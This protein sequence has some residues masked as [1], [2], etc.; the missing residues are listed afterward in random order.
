MRV[1]VARLRVAYASGMLRLP[2]WFVT[3]HVQLDGSD[4]TPCDVPE[5]AMAFT[6]VNGMLEFQLAHEG[7]EWK[8]SLA[9][10]RDGLIIVIADLHR[11]GTTT[12]V[13]DSETDGTGG[14]QV[15]LTDLMAFAAAARR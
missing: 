11:A 7:G 2:L 15:S 12:I 10:D 6:S 4:D 9:A 14:E 5:V 8:M 3:E 1:V 13:L